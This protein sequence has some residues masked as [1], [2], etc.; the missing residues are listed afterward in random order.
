MSLI[1]TVFVLKLEFLIVLVTVKKKYQTIKCINSFIYWFLSLMVS[2]FPSLNTWIKK[3]NR[4]I[5]IKLNIWMKWNKTDL[6]KLARFCTTLAMRVSVRDVC[7]SGYSWVR[8]KSDGDMIAGHR[9]RRKREPLMRRSAM[10]S[11]PLSAQRTRQEAKTS[12]SSRGNTL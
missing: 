12:F 1:S 6:E 8:L 11:R 5:F 3:K 9:K 10:S 2:F 4:I 7:S